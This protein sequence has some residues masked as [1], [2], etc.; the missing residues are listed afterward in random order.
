LSMPYRPMPHRCMFPYDIDADDGR[1]PQIPSHRCHMVQNHNSELLLG[2]VLRNLW[3]LLK[4]NYPELT[5]FLM[6]DLL[7]A[8]CST[9]IEKDGP[10]GNRRMLSLAVG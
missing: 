9:I 7:H 4:R 6:R 1:T 5:T 8:H 2:L 10:K 3:V